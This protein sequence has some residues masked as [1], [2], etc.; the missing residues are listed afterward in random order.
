MRIHLFILVVFLVVS[1]AH[2]TRADEAQSRRPFGGKEHAIPGKIEAEHYD[3]GKPG[4]AYH[5]VDEKNHGANYRGVTQVD[6]EKRDDASGG[7]GVG[8]T[9]AGEWVTYSVVVKESGDYDVKFVLSAPSKGGVIHLDFNGKDATGPIAVPNTGSFQTLGSV[10]KKKV[11]LKAGEYVMK[12]VMDANGKSGY[13]ADIDSIEFLPAAP[14][15]A[16]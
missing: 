9:K 15:S 5:D 4:E 16:Q 7:H 13:V 2:P 10:V 1:A 12:M 6:I 8:W 14:A 3:E 11:P